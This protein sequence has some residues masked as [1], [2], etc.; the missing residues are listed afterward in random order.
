MYEISLLEDPLNSYLYE[1]FAWFLL[2]KTDKF[3][4][5]LEL[6]Q[7]AYELGEND[8]A[9][10]V[11]LGISHH[12]LGNLLEGDEYIEYSV[13]KGRSEGFG[14]FRKGLARYQLANSSKTDEEKISLYS[15]A[16]TLLKRTQDYYRGM[17][18]KGYDIKIRDDANKYLELSLQRFNK[19]RNI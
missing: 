2:N 8:V 15:Q 1:R 6:S 3:S 17:H 4:R 11:S 16:I 5:A 18:V 14:L 7:E 10:I 12:K 13:R 19:A 9:A